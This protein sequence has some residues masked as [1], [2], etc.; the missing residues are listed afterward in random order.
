MVGSCDGDGD[1]D[2]AGLGGCC[3]EYWEDG[4]GV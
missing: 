4:D 2:V 3:V 1:G